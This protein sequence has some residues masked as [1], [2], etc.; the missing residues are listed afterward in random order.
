MDV[1][2][3]INE[4]NLERFRRLADAVTTAAERKVLLELLA[5]E[6]NK[7]IELQRTVG[8]TRTV[9]FSAG[10]PAAPAGKSRP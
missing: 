2:R 6:K 9:S 7:F 1:D 4:L 5:E 3:F 10:R 8:S